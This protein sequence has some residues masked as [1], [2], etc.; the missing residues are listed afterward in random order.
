MN[1]EVLVLTIFYYFLFRWCNVLLVFNFCL[2]FHQVKHRFLLFLLLLF[3][4][5]GFLYWYILFLFPTI[6]VRNQIVLSRKVKMI[7]YI[8]F[9]LRKNLHGNSLQNVLFW[10]K[11]ATC[12]NKVLAIWRKLLLL[13]LLKEKLF[14]ISILS[15]ICDCIYLRI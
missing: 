1:S 14:H 4:S 10:V 9:L 3:F 15:P 12:F 5:T 13:T 6:K 2:P 11:I 8:M 7:L